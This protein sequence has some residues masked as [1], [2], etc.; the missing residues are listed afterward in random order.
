MVEVVN[1]E[2]VDH[3]GVAFF[4]KEWLPNDLVALAGMSVLLLLGIPDEADLGSVFG[5]SAP[6]TIGAMF[7]LGEAL[8]RTGVIDGIAVCFRNGRVFPDFQPGL[9]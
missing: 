6:L 7:I 2:G 8:T 3:G 4:V 5:N 1:V 9:V